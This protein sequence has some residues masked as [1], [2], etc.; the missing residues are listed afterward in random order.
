MLQTLSVPRIAYTDFEASDE[1]M[2]R[3]QVAE[4]FLRRVR[5]SKDQAELK[6]LVDDVTREIGFQHFAL[7]HH[8]DLGRA[9]PYVIRLENYPPG[10]VEYFIEH[11]LYADDPIHRACLV[12]AVGFSWAEVSEKISLTKRQSS[13][14][15]KAAG[16]GLCNGYTVPI[17][18]PGESSGSCSFATEN[19]LRPENLLLAELIG[20]FAFEA[21]RRLVPAFAP[22]FR[23]PPRLTAR[24]HDCLVLAIQGKTDWEIGRILGLS[25]ETVTQHLDMARGR[26]GVTKRL[27][28][29]VRA[30]Y[31]GQIG[32]IEALSG[33]FPLKRE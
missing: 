17:N 16:H 28:L 25:E 22:P 20:A 3:L 19:A 30:I 29:A 8:V 24:Q 15:E 18:I 4:Q 32:F 1:T 5:D 23:E 31:D 33:Q 2:S 11:K 12:S 27:P 13:I 7:V 21:A 26:Y 10:W 14:L 6:S 9:S